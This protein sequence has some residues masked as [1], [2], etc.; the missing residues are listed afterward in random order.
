MKTIEN[1]FVHWKTSLAGIIAAAANMY[2]GGH[3]IGSVAV[4]AG[5]AFLGL[6]ASDASTSAAK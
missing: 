3:S 2:A 1:W 5:I 6:F 4:S